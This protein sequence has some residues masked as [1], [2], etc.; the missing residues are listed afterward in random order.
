M[1][2]QLHAAA[3]TS[4]AAAAD[5]A[6]RPVCPRAGRPAW[7]LFRELHAVRTSNAWGP[8]PI[9]YTEI[10]AYQAVTRQPLHPVEVELIRALDTEY[11]IHAANR[12][13][14]PPEETPNG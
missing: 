7:R 6:S 10:A 12:Q 11:L 5:L 1:R 13:A 9:T 3:L 2:E 14:P 4:A 8:N